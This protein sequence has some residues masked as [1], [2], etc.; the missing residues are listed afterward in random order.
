MKHT[1][2]WIV[3]RRNLVFALTCGIILFCTQ[4]LQAQAYFS[5]WPA[6]T[7]PQEVGRRVAENLVARR[8][9]VEDGKRKSVIYP[10]ACAWYGSLTV[11]QLTKDSDLR[12]R[13]IRK[14]DPL[15]GEHANWISQDAHVDM[16]VLG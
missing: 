1:G 7:S 5:N 16:R 9:E 6:G 10:E 13:L 8:L 2:G 4:R 3:Y 14:F 12:N 11:A 15:L